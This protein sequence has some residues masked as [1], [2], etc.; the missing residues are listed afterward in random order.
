MVDSLHHRSRSSL[1]FDRNIPYHRTDY[2]QNSHHR[3]AV[4]LLSDGQWWPPLTRRTGSKI[5]LSSC[6]AWA[7][8]NLRLSNLRILYQTWSWWRVF[9]TIK[10]CSL[11]IKIGS[12]LCKRLKNF[13][14]L[15]PLI[16]KALTNAEMHKGGI[17]LFEYFTKYPMTL[18]Y[19]DYWILIKA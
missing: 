2:H 6:D 15:F 14:S 12:T 19:H 3:I 5:S 11:V 4:R 18:T 13:H 8:V 9:P 7:Q 17:T 16:S 10:G 1:T